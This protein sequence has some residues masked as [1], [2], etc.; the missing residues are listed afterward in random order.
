MS[1]YSAFIYPFGSLLLGSLVVLNILL[2]WVYRKTYKSAEQFKVNAERIQAAKSDAEIEKSRAETQ[3]ELSTNDADRLREELAS[4][5]TMSKKLRQDIAR[6]E[7][8]LS[9]RQSSW[10][11]ERESLN[12]LHADLQKEFKRLAGEVLE[13]SNQTFLQTA[14]EVLSNE[15]KLAKKDEETRIKAVADLVDPVK[16]SIAKLEETSRETYGSLAEQLRSVTSGQEA[17]HKEA[18]KL[19]NALRRAP[20]TRGKWGEV[21]LHNI[22]ELSGMSPHC[23]FDKEVT[24]KDD[25]GSVRPDVIIRLP[26]NR[27]L[28]VDA[29]TSLDAYLAAI[30]EV[31]EQTREAELERH[32]RQVRTHMEQLARKKY[33]QRINDTL[34]FTV[35]FI[36]GENFFA[37]A[38]ERDSTLFSDAFEKGI[39]IL[40]PA[41]LLAMAKAVSL[42]WRQ[43]ALA[44]NAQKV[45]EI[46]REMYSRLT[47]MGGHIDD[48]GKNLE[49]A[50]QKYNKFVGSLE[51]SVLSQG[52]R[53]KDLQVA[54]DKELNAPQSVKSEIRKIRADKYET[55]ALDQKDL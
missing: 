5:Q 52:R 16:K 18:G 48:L 37:A 2:F 24:F 28:I 32:A 22:L 3:A 55:P 21:Q 47:T 15:Q 53:F 9:E 23:D 25:G 43:E 39:V 12:A 4:E 31:D 35:M 33:H 54:T 13:S 49:S 20:Q 1:E 42:G 46:G 26:A 27:I 51:T 44:Q 17:V 11:T 14:K 7:T 41:T 6:L 29:K 45:A 8:T 19:V 10:E 36:P 38:L 30:D 50:T 34:D 40:T